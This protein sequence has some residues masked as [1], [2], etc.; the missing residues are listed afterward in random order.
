KALAEATP[1]KSVLEP[2]LRERVA[3][4]PVGEM[5][6]ALP[7]LPREGQAVL[8]RTL[9]RVPDTQVSAPFLSLL[10]H[11]DPWVRGSIARLLADRPG[12][13]V[14]PALRDSL[15]DANKSVRLEA[16]TSLRTLQAREAVPALL[17]ALEDPDLKVQSAAIDALRELADVSA[18]PGL[19]AA[20]TNDSEYV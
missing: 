13:G 8:L 18:V 10:Q 1:A 19:V 16:V 6:A 4:L 14:V 15:R 5:V 20:L 17:G 2:I 12:P 9:E 7:G 3:D 11:E